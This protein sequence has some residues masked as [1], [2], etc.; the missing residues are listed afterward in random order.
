MALS[1][2]STK[3]KEHMGVSEQCTQCGKCS[4]G[5]PA[6]RNLD[7]RPRKIAL[8][9]Q[10]GQ[11]DPLLSSNTIWM[12]TQC[13]QCME[14]CPREV[15]PYDIIIF[16]QNLAVRR[17]YPYP[18]ELNMLLSSVKR[19]GSIQLPQEVLDNEFENYDRES[20]S[21]PET[22][23]PKDMEALCRA[24]ERIMEDKA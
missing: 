6:A 17:G 23:G 16:L 24:L 20:L 12:C 3:E 10:R 21:L 8:L 19:H 4:S 9:A 18:R 11:I 22:R 13:H 2:L 1:R 14:R 7:L 5:C 15:T